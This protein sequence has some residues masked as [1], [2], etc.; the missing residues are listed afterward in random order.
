MIICDAILCLLYNL[1]TVRRI[2]TNL[3]T[4]VKLIQMTCHGQ[5]PELCFGHFWSYF[6]VIICDAI[7]CLLYNLITVR[8]ISTNL[9]T[10][11]KLIQMMCHAKEP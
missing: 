5:E 4:F 9:H 1:I 6:P 2:S 3:H 10:F 8:G 11:V 7:L